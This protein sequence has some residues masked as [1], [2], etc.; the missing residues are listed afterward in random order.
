VARRALPQDV[1]ILRA[2]ARSLADATQVA[3]ELRQRFGRLDAACL[4]AGIGRMLPIEAV[5][6][7]TFDEH[8][9]VNVKGQYFTLQ[10]SCRS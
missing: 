3:D 9:A 10:K 2:D 4:N 5:D 7:A 8:F 6:E 1:A